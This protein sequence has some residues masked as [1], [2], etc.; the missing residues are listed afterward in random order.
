TV[1]PRG[2]L[3]VADDLS[4]TIWRVTPNA[5]S[6]GMVPAAPAPA[7]TAGAMPASTIGEARR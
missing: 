1:D 7:T 4:N 3:I 5:A 2:A 6:A